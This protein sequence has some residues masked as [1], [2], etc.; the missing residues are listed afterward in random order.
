MSQFK[1][2]NRTTREEQIFNS[3]ELETFF[4]CEYDIKTQKVKYR[5]KFNDY[6][7]SSIKSEAR[8][9]LDAFVISICSLGL[10]IY[11]TKIILIWN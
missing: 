1:V 9:L 8:K 10:I 6:A 7:I 11:I 4:Y 2:I 3:K 5:N